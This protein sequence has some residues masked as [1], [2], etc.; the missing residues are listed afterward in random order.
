MISEYYKS[1][2]KH[3]WRGNRQVTTYHQGGQST[4]NY[5]DSTPP[6]LIPPVEK[7]PILLGINST[8]LVSTYTKAS[9]LGITVDEYDK[10]DRIV[11]EAARVCP[12][13]VGDTIFSSYPNIHEKHGGFL[14]I[15]IA[16]SYE[17]IKLDKWEDNKK[18][19]ILTLRALRSQTKFISTAEDFQRLNPHPQ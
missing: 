8:P 2:R 14:I 10:R 9:A 13:K 18:P 3:V 16:N 15:G 6:K 7:S 12:Y 17:D 4:A 5:G 19:Q 11:K 1:T